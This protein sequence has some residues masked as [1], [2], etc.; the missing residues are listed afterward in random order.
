MGIGRSEREGWIDLSGPAPVADSRPGH[1]SSA[2]RSSGEAYNPYGPEK[3]KR[4]PSRDG[5]QG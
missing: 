4:A 5:F 3:D 2:R 1:R